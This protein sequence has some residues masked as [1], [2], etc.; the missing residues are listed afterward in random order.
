MV[1]LVFCLFKFL[2][3]LA[4]CSFYPLRRACDTLCVVYS[5]KYD[6][7]IYVYFVQDSQA[8]WVFSLLGP[9]FVGGKLRL[10]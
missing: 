8:L 2:V 5:V 1:W 10:F 4:V 6:L 7:S 9:R 3:T